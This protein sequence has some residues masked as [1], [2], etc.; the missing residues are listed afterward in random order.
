MNAHYSVVAQRARHRCEYCRAPEAIFNFP[1]E[2][3]HILPSSQQG[4]D[5]EN[6]LALACR[7]CN[8]SKS[9]HVTARDDET[10]GTVRLFHPRIDLWDEHFEFIAETG[11]IRGQ[12]P[13]GRATAER[14]CVNSR[15][16]RE[17][18][19]QWIRLG[20]YP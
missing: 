11:I 13:I 20:L 3:E 2:V 1:F 6:N 5:L 8:L 12:T 18:R 4:V 15:L 14:L 17:A 16:Q 9:S 7:S 19:S 10:K